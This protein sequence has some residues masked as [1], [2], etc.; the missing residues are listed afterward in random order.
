MTLDLLARLAAV[1]HG[2]T[3]ASGALLLLMRR[4]LPPLREEDVVRAFRATG[5]ILGLTLGAFIL[6]EA[7]AWPDRVNPDATGLGRWA[8]PAT[9]EGLRLGLFGVYWVSYTLLEIWTI[10]PCRLGDRDGRIEDPAAYAA[11]ASRVTRHATFNALVFLAV[12]ALGIR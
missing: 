8:V 10:E 6:G 11:A 12:V 7:V 1:V 9:A 3:L 5:V 2:G 4:A